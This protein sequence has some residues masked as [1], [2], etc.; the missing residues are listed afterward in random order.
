MKRVIIT[1]SNGTGKSHVAMHL[2][3]ARPDLPVIS[4]EAIRLTRNWIK[5]SPAEI[6][7]A[8]SAVIEKDAWV[9]EGGPS[10][11]DHALWRC[12]GVIWL[13]P[14]NLVRAWRLALRPWKNLG[15]ARPELPPGNV[16]WPLQQYGF[17]LRS[18]RKGRHFHNRIETALRA[19]PPLQ[20]WHYKSHRDVE[21]AITAISHSSPR[22]AQEK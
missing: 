10:L 13:D 3:K 17:A 16:D 22:K 20:V 8:L 7:A 11:L 1:G 21:A 18:L 14:P 4:Y 2:A 12:Q 9:L 5:K 19:T 6:E 15:R